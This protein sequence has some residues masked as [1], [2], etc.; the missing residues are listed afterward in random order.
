MDI[1]AETPPPMRLSSRRPMFMAGD[2]AG[3]NWTQKLVI[4]KMDHAVPGMLRTCS[5]VINGNIRMPNNGVIPPPR[6]HRR[7]EFYSNAG[8]AC[9]SPGHGG[10]CNVHKCVNPRC[11]YPRLPGRPQCTHCTLGLTLLTQSLY[12]MIPETEL[13]PEFTTWPGDAVHLTFFS[14]MNPNSKKGMRSFS[15]LADGHASGIM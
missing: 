10:S 13:P 8:V 2:R 12:M 11:T 3:P 14:R 6:L 5:V 1:A 7:C 9:T 15:C 4:R